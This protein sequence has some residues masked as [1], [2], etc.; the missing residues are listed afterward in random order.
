[1]RETLPGTWR[2]HIEYT[3][4]PAWHATN[5][6]HQA[7]WA[8]DGSGS[9]FTTRNLAHKD[10]GTSAERRTYYPQ[11]G[12]RYFDTDL[13]KLLISTDPA[14]RKWVDAMGNVVE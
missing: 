7:L 6:V 10:I 4:Q 3:M 12:Q 13:G 5:A 1:M 14:R 9:G 11:L 8:A 2:G